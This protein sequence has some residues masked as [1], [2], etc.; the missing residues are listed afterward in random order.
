MLKQFLEDKLTQDTKVLKKAKTEFAAA[1]T[2]EKTDLVEASKRL[3]SLKTSQAASQSTCSQVTSD[4]EI[5]VK[6]FAEELRTLA[7]AT[8]VIQDQTAGA[9][10]QAYSLFQQSSFAG[11]QTKTEVK[12]FEVVT[13][14]RELAKKEHSANEAVRAVDP[15]HG[16]ES[17]SKANS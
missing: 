1:L 5:S 3:V 6:D 17:E 14:V 15:G 9:K 16:V 7:E 13:M 10:F 2:A 11:L 12:R 4:H 8:Q